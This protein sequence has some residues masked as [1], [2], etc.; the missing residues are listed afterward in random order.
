MVNAIA[1]I[2]TVLDSARQTLLLN[3]IGDIYSKFK[4]KL[5]IKLSKVKVELEPA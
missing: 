4:N 5:W 3:Q 2:P 1:N